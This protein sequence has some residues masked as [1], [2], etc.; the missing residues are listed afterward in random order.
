MGGVHFLHGIL[1][2]LGLKDED[3]V[4]V[5]CPNEN[6][7]QPLTGFIVQGAKN[8]PFFSFKKII[9]HDYEFLN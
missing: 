7:H 6:C 3:Q 2:S 8:D 9:S 4:Q 5:V 1:K